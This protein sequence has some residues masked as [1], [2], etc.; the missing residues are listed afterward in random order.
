MIYRRQQPTRSHFLA[1]FLTGAV[2]GSVVGL[3]FGTE[4]G[5]AA[6]ERLEEAVNEV[7]GRF[8]GPA[9]EK[10]EVEVKG[11]ASEEETSS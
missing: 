4:L 10:T 2:V 1:G 6:R 7:R 5:R 9:T 8:N 11:T 3:F